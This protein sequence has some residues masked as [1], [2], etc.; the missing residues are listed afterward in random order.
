MLDIDRSEQ[1]MDG[2]ILSADVP[3]CVALVPS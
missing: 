2:E 3:G 1:A